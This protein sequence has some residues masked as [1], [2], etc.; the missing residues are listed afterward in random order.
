MEGYDA[1]SIQKAIS[2]AVEQKGL[3]ITKMMGLGS[4]C[5]GDGGN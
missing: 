1:D 5:I 4:E 2:D 3:D